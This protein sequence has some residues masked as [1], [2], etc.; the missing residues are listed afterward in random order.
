MENQKIVVQ[1]Y[2][3]TQY[4]NATSVKVT[5]NI[6]YSNQKVSVRGVCWNTRGKPTNN[7]ICF[8]EFF[9]IFL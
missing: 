8:H 9:L 7:Y 6:F 2:G 3:V 4:Q 5:G 1:T